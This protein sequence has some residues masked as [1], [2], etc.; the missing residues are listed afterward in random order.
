MT[1]V[2]P[3]FKAPTMPRGLGSKEFVRARSGGWCEAGV[4]D[5][6]TRHGTE[7]HHIVRRSQGGTNDD[8][9]LRLLCHQCHSWTHRN[10]AAAYQLGLLRRSWE[11]S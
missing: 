11:Q 6:C 8:E 2:T 4:S 9:N 7:L 5:D 1:D 10:V 3:R